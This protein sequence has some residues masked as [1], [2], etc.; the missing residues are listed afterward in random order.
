MVMYYRYMYS[1]L[2]ANHPFWIILRQYLVDVDR[3]DPKIKI[4][5]SWA[6]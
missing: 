2:V 4:T 6:N 1:D 5:K 3:L